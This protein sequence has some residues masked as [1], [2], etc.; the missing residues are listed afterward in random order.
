MVSL[1]IQTEGRSAAALTEE[2]R[3]RLVALPPDAVARIQLQGPWTPAALQ[4]LSA[5]SLRKVAPEGMNVAV[6]GSFRATPGA[7]GQPVR[8]RSGDEPGRLL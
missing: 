7:P 3:A 2:L 5:P 8:P 6:A 4:A 1:A